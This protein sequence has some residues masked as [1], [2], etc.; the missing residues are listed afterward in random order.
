MARKFIFL[1][2]NEENENRKR[3]NQKANFEKSSKNTDIAS[4]A[5]SL[6]LCTSVA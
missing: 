5:I 4:V 6:A 3:R 2:K 1:T